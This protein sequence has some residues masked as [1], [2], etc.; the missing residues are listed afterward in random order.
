M[1]FGCY[2]R[3]L[4]RGPCRLPPVFRVALAIAVGMLVRTDA[5]AVEWYLNAYGLARTYQIARFDD[6]GFPSPV[7]PVI[8]P[9]G[10][11]FD[12][13]HVAWPSAVRVG[14]RALVFASG[15]DGERWG[16]VGLWTSS[17]GVKFRREGPV[18]SAS[19]SE[20]HG[21]GPAHV[22]YD[23]TLGEPFGMYFLIRGPDGPGPAIGYATS[24]DG[25]SWTRRGT[26]LVARG[27]EEAAGLSVSYAC[28]LSTGRW[29]LFYQG[30]RTL[31]EAAALVATAEQPG[32]PFVR[33][34]VL[35]RGDGV[36]V[37]VIS[38]S[39]GTNFVVVDNAA[40]LVR[41]Q[42][43]FIHS[44]DVTS[45]ELV[46]IAAIKGNHVFLTWP[47]L[48][49][50]TAHS[51]LSLT[52]AKVDPSYAK[53]TRDAWEGIFT[54]YE[55]APGVHAEYTFRVRGR[56]LRSTWKILPDGVRF[57]PWAPELWYSA[58]NP[59]PLARSAS[60]G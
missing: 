33:R 24:I 45:S 37:R 56:D 3:G 52:R 43:Y 7:D 32:G 48:L 47:L 1:C 58:E 6:A 29:V 4:K 54:G 2:G 8:R 15:N 23:P 11:G 14:A 49:D 30:N 44:G 28:R 26:A 21:I 35:M 31:K 46:Q 39:R 10:A 50:H 27:I 40:R 18:F 20:P 36:E 34:T 59:V 51:M 57:K 16:A 9:S 55:P 42:V 13:V 25:R 22:S 5:E 60:C 38:G 17:D 53:K 41:G 19:G 12:A